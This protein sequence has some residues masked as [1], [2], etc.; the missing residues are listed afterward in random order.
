MKPRR[1]VHA[2][3][4]GHWLDSL[5]ISV[6][7]MSVAEWGEF[8]YRSVYGGSIPGRSSKQA[9]MHACASVERNKTLKIIKF[10]SL[11]FS[12]SLFLCLSVSVYVY[13]EW[14]M[15]LANEGKGVLNQRDGFEQQI[16]QNQW[17]VAYPTAKDRS[18]LSTAL[19]RWDLKLAGKVWTYHSAMIASANCCL[20]STS[21]RC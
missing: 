6:S 17:T 2:E 7:G 10:V 3:M 1:K 20:I 11:S 18:G 8:S 14:K 4:Y 16:Q 13:D 19:F 21:M 9:C 15:L 5:K 12:L